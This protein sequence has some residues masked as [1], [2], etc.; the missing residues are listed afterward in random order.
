MCCTIHGSHP[1]AKKA[2]TKYPHIVQHYKCALLAG[3]LR[4]GHRLYALM[5]NYA[6]GLV[7]SAPDAPLI[8]PYQSCSIFALLFAPSQPGLSI[9]QSDSQ[10]KLLCQQQHGQVQKVEARLQ[11]AAPRGGAHGAGA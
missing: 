1:S 10:A 4:M 9:A 8:N 3:C 5:L 7:I 6:M 2:A 11:P